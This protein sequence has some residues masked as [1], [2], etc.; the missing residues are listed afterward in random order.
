MNAKG[1]NVIIVYLPKIKVSNTYL[2]RFRKGRKKSGH[3]KLTILEEIEELKLI[4]IISQFC[5]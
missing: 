4:F 2:Q 5:I 3:L 1:L